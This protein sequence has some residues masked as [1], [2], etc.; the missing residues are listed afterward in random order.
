MPDTRL[1]DKLLFPSDRRM[2]VSIKPAFFVAFAF[3]AIAPVVVAWAQF[4]FLGLP[5]IPSPAHTNPLSVSD[6]IGF[7]V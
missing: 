5:G 3:L 2:R 6:P 4:F 7:P 1:N